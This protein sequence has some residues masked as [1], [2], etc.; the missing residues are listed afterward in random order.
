MAVKIS[1]QFGVDSLQFTKF[2]CAY[3]FLHEAV[4]GCFV[5]GFG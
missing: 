5:S 4:D 2:H 1:S 3:I